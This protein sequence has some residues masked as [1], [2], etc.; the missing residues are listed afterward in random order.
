MLALSTQCAGPDLSLPDALASFRELGVRAAVL[1]RMATAEEARALAGLARR[2]AVVAVFG[3][4]PGPGV[5]A[6]I[7]VV[8]GGPVGEDRDRS[9]EELC[10]RLH[11]LRDYEVALRTPPD[12][13]HHPAPHELALVREALAHV[14]YWHDAGLGGDDYLDAGARYLLGAS[15]DPL[16]GVDL[17]GLHDALP[18]AAPA[19]VV[20]EPDAVR[21]ALARA[22]GFWR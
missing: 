18:Q 7:L 22:R 13:G 17:P 3:D 2:I 1:H 20:C 16:G 10:R 11:A 19:T 15:F 4:E 6:R 8:E 9:L 5:G 12:A 21:D 14:G